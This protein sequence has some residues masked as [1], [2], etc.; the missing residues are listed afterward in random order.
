MEKEGI[1]SE[2][3]LVATEN[4][5]TV[6]RLATKIIEPALQT[7]LAEAKEEGTPQE[8]VSALANCYVGLLVDLVGRK[9]ASTLL[10]NHAHHVLSREEE[11][12]TN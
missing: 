12:L 1:S 10:Q 5:E 8:V 3:K 6:M 7:A 4:K 11:V 2:S 9:G